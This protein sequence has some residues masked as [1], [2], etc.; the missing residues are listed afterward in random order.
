MLRSVLAV[1]LASLVAGCFNVGWSG[2]ALEGSGV[3]GS[4]TVDVDPFEG[5][6]LG[7][8]GV[9]TVT[10]GAAPLRVEGDDNLVEALVA[11]VEDGVLRLRAPR[12]ESFRPELD[13]RMTVGADRLASV[14]VSGTGRVEADRAAADRVEVS[15]GGSGEADLAGI[16]AQA[17]GVSVAG[18]GEVVLGGRAES[19]EVEVAGSGDVDAAA[20][21]AG[22]AAVSVAGSGDVTVRAS[23]ALSVSVAG[24]GDVRYYGSPEVSTSIAGSGDVVRL[25]G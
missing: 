6:A 16:D 24:S 2:P 9:L 15:V 22:D 12:G 5:V 20:L 23:K 18:S 21:D 7:V 17:V 10:S 25:D 19:L 1:A 13:F 8:P 4:R 14:A 11:E 3:A